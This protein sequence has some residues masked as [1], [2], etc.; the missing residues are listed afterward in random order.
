MGAWDSLF[1]I[2]GLAFGLGLLHALDADH[3]AAVSAFAGR[4]DGPAKR[5][6]RFCLRWALGH[7]CTLLLLGTLVLTL[8]IAIP[9]SL[10]RYAE[11][12]V[13]L[14]LLLMGA[15]LL[16]DIRRQSLRVGFHSHPGLLRHAHWQRPAT[17][18]GRHGHGATLV[19]ALHGA[20]GSAPLL[21][22]IPVATHQAPWWGLLYLLLFS[23]AVLATMLA[24]GGLLG[25]L[26]SRLARWG[27]NALRWVRSGIAGG[28]LLTGLYL[29]HGLI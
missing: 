11:A 28:A 10:G 1:G 8:G 17:P 20:A 2:L 7:G 16:Y 22:L 29:L 6:W 27:S 24:F 26:F 12:S 4:G 19:G 18:S 5:P 14:V 13:G 9:P 3:V 15:V 25:V 23:I 21:A